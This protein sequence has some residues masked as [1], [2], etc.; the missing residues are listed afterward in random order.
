M[1]FLQLSKNKNTDNLIKTNFKENAL[2]NIQ[3]N[4]YWIRTQV[5]PQAGINSWIKCG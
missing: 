4:N 1:G 5:V 2:E 3:S